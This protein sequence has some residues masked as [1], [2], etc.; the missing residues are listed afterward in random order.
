[1]VAFAVSPVTRPA[2]AARP[3]RLS[4]FDV[5]LSLT[6]RT[7]DFTWDEAKSER[8][9]VERD[10]PFGLVAELFQRFVIDQVDDRRD[11]GERRMIALGEVRGGVLVCVCTDRADVRRIISLRDANRREP[12]A[13]RAAYPS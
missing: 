11:Y 9:G 1:L 8:N 13:Y 7:M 3:V 2:L 10:L 4:V 5:R 12:H 6:Y